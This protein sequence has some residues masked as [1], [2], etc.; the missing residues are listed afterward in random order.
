MEDKTALNEVIKF[1]SLFVC[2]VELSNEQGV[3]SWAE[4]VTERRERVLK[5]LVVDASRLISEK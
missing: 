5:L 1:D 4:I 2:S 3:D